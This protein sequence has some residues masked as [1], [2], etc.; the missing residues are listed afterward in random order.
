MSRSRLAPLATAALTVLGVSLLHPEAAFAAAPTN[1]TLAGI[2]TLGP[3][4]TTVSA[5]TTEATTDADDT[6]INADCG[7]P[8]TDASV[9]YQFTPATDGNYLLGLSADYSAGAIVATGGPGSWQLQGCAPGAVGFSA[10]A[11]TTYTILVFDDQSDGGGNGGHVDVTLE[12]APPTP[13]VSV[14]V[15][16]TARF[17]KDGSVL[18]TGQVTCSAGAQTEIDADLTQRVGRLLIRGSAW[19]VIDCGDGSAQPWSMVVSGDNGLFRGGKAASVE[20]AYACGAFD[21]GTD[22]K[23][24]TV[25][26][27]G[28]K[29]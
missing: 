13:E 1:D 11:G 28:G 4:P 9:W 27:S 20:T 3:V 14:A 26:V 16:P 10:T 15:D 6:A 5:D 21:C 25:K 18:L 23:A 29:G 2:T 22:Y 7:A 19:T 24:V 12:P 8:A 17:M